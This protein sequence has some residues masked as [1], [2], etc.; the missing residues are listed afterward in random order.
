MF[1]ELNCINK[2]ERSAKKELNKKD[3]LI[4]NISYYDKASGD[5]RTA[6]HMNNGD[7]LYTKYNKTQVKKKIDKVLEK[8]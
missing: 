6:L 2:Q 1:I 7:V 3:I 8:L 4:G 5:Y